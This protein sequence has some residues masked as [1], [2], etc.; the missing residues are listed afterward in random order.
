MRNFLLGLI[1]FAFALFFPYSQSGSQEYNAGQLHP[2]VKYVAIPSYPRFAWALQKQGEVTALVEI[3]ANGTV[4]E[5]RSIK[6]PDPDLFSDSVTRSLREWRFEPSDTA[7]ELSVVFRFRLSGDSE[8]CPASRGSAELP[9]LIEVI[10]P[11]PLYPQGPD[12]IKPSKQSK[13]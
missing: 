7:S 1:G 5:V 2:R 12:S 3:G 4:F 9:G 13:N 8:S 11:P 6:G 10:S